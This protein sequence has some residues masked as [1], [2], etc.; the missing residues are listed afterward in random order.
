MLLPRRNSVSVL[1]KAMHS[2]SPLPIMSAIKS[3]ACCVMLH[4][5]GYRA[6]TH[7]DQSIPMEHEVLCCGHCQQRSH[8]SQ[9][10]GLPIHLA[11]LLDEGHHLQTRDISELQRLC[12]ESS[13]LANQHLLLTWL[14]Q[15]RSALVSVAIR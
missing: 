12:A 14:Q 13:E 11:A 1:K 2:Q 9:L 3:P 10:H 4:P 8:H 15:R 7:R 5:M 6:A